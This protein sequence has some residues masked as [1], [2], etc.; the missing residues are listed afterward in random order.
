MVARFGI[1][2]YKF[3]YQFSYFILDAIKG[4][5]GLRQAGVFPVFKSPLKKF[6]YGIGGIL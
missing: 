5:V 6:N 2:F 1:I 4:V 3:D